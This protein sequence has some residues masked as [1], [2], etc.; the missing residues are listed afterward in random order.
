MQKLLND[1]CPYIEEESPNFRI[2]TTTT[3]ARKVKWVS[4]T[5]YLQWCLQWKDVALSDY[6]ADILTFVVNLA[7]GI[8]HVLLKGMLCFSCQSTIE[9]AKTLSNRAEKTIMEIPQEWSGLST[10]LVKTVGTIPAFLPPP[11]TMLIFH[12]LRNQDPFID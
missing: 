2:T 9:S 5:E 12:G 6:G 11:I 8:F 1:I 7:F 3:K 4:V 10:I